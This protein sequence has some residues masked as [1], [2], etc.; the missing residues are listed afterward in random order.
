M[1]SR[2]GTSHLRFKHGLAKTRDQALDLRVKV[3]ASH[4][5]IKHCIRH[6]DESRDAFMLAA[7]KA[8]DG[9]AKFEAL[10]T[11]DQ[12]LR[13]DCD[14]LKGAMEELRLLHF[15]LSNLDFELFSEEQ[16]QAGAHNYLDN[17]LNPETT[18]PSTIET[19]TAGL[20]MPGDNNEIPP[21][22]EEYFDVLGDSRLLKERLDYGLLP[23]QAERAQR[24]EIKRDQD[25]VLSMSDGEFER[26]L[27]TER[28]DLE[29]E[30]EELRC[31]AAEL[32]KQC[33][34][35]GLDPD[36]TKY[37]RHSENGSSISHN[38]SKVE[39]WLGYLGDD[40]P[41]SGAGPA[42][43]KIRSE[44]DDGSRPTTPLQETVIHDSLV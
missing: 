12:Q 26:S 10:K 1:D 9:T 32:L 39:R 18:A 14:T 17:F 6:F 25:D 41:M 42:H 22:L 31:R 37:A 36:P 33:L 44:T 38:E 4:G 7:Q 11:A 34:K 29:V 27:Y 5:K 8:L 3:Q 21:L 2:L 20:D 43:D 16:K 30:L 13:E 23:E 28:E 35:A 24:R 19:I 40:G 15:N